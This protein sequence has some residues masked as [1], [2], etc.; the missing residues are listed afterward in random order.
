MTVKYDD[1]EALTHG[2]ITEKPLRKRPLYPTW[3]IKLTMAVTGL[4]F[5]MFAMVHMVGNM[6]IFLPDHEDGTP[7]I[8]TYGKF[9][10]TVGE[11]V[12]PYGS[13]LW[14]LRMVLLVAIILHIYGAF[15]IVGRA[16]RSRGKFRRTNMMG[17]LQ[18]FATR[19]MIVTGIVLLAFI[20]FHILDLTAGVHPAASASFE[21]GAVHSNVVATFSRPAVSIFYI[22]AQLCLF[23]HLTHGLWVVVSDLGVVGKRWRAI[24]SVVAYIVPAIVLLGNVMIPVSVMVGWVS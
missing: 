10:R 2:K 19:T 6:K 7:A 1:R 14:M 9:F 24:L 3:A 22:I 15:A 18:N 8:D 17:G 21:H 11:P 23:L 12:F 20:I 16:H 5:G 4:L 13:I